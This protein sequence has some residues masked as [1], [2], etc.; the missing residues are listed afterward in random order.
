MMRLLKLFVIAA[1]ITGAAAYAFRDRW[2]DGSFKPSLGE[3]PENAKKPLVPVP[4]MLVMD[5]GEGISL[6]TKPAVYWNRENTEFR[7]SS[8]WVGAGAGLL[9]LDKNKND[10]IDN[11]AELFG[12]QIGTDIN[13]SM[14]ALAA[15]D[16]NK[17]GVIDSSDP[18]FPD[19][20]VWL[21]QGDGH[22]QLSE[23]HNLS[24]LGITSISL[25]FH[26]ENVPKD[27][28]HFLGDG[29]FIMQ[30][31]PRKMT[32]VS[33]AYEK[34]NTV[35]DGQYTLNP[36]ILFLPALRGYGD[37][38]DLHIAMSKDA[39]L[40]HMVEQV[41]KADLKTLLSMNFNVQGK[42]EA[43]LFRWAGSEDA[44]PVRRGGLF[45]ERKLRV[46]EKFMGESFLNSI[47]FPPQRKHLPSL[48]QSWSVSFGGVSANIL[49]QQFAFGKLY[50]HPIYD[51]ITDRFQGMGPLPSAIVHFAT[52]SADMWTNSSKMHNIY[53]FYPNS[54]SFFGTA[55][56]IITSENDGG[57]DIIFAGIQSNDVHIVHEADGSLTVQY[58]LRGRIHLVR[59]E[60]NSHNATAFLDRIIFDDGTVWTKTTGQF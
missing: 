50:G 17:D 14:D 48:E 20:R 16:L 2:L 52:S 54:G 19:L 60:G 30:G 25:Q 13:S 34:V 31:E 3:C 10:K 39:R 44:D 45:D 29:A 26:A 36:V 41:A 43:I 28:N 46:L 9:C 56:E 35:Y 27:G 37:L 21:D 5:M 24:E 7:Q 6:T 38:P 51:A 18:V 33:L 40:M 23:L 47:C 59:A 1:V 15:Y 12:A 11:N 32:E 57:T 53:I 49:L 42:I 55:D 4:S 58:S 22:S 8:A